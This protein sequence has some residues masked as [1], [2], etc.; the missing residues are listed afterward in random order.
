MK[1]T[2]L[3]KNSFQ[4][5]E[6]VVSTADNSKTIA[7]ESKAD[8]LGSSINGGELL[9]LSLA[10]CFCNDV[11]REAGKRNLEIDNVEVVVSGEFG[12]EGEPAKHIS[13]EVKV[14]AAKHSEEEIAALIKRVDEV[15]EIH[16]T[17]RKGIEI[18][19]R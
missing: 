17:L 2:A 6:V 1:I 10:T 12:G 8:G 13:Y 9:F 7:I 5:H 4:K 15:A 11:Y 3:V 18:K 19:L 16:N 14:E